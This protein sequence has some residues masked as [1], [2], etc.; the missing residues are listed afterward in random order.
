MQIKEI[1]ERCRKFEIYEQRIVSDDYAEVVMYIKEIFKWSAVFNEIFGAP[2]SPAGIKP[3]FENE[4]IAREYGGIFTDQT[5][6]KKDFPEYTLLAMFWP[7]QDGKRSTVKV[8]I[9]GK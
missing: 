1:I 9:L 3:T 6:Y 4:E 5:L 2:V 7:W 8:A